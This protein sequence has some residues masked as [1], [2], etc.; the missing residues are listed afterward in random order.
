MVI[1]DVVVETCCSHGYCV[2][3]R[4]DLCGERLWDGEAEPEDVNDVENL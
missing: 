4:L 2:F 1:V 3:P